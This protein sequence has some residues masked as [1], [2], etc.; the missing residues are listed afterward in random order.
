LETDAAEL[1]RVDGTLS[2]LRRSSSAAV[3]A[4]VTALDLE[5]GRLTERAVQVG[6]LRRFIRE[7]DQIS[8]RLDEFDRRISRLTEVAERR[9]QK[10]T[11]EKASDVLADRMNDY[12]RALNEPGH[13]RWTQSEVSLLLRPRG[14]TFLVAGK[15]WETKLGGS[16]TLYFLLAYHYGLLTLSAVDQSN[17]PGIIVLDFPPSL[18][19]GVDVK[20]K[21]NYVLRPFDAILRH[22]SF[23]GRQVIAAG[24]TFEGLEVARRIQ[25][26]RV[27]R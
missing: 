14:F 23:R 22:P 19:E 2:S 12:L 5:I 4:A 8:G 11:L 24:S 3:T 6:R 26:R 25:L 21:E 17:S 1:E 10:L 13:L 15:P 16:L 7:R 9:K 20:D 27:W 18:E